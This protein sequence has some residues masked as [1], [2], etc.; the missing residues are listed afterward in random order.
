MLPAL[1]LSALQGVLAVAV[2][3]A[4]GFAGV[5]WSPSLPEWVFG[6]GTICE[7]TMRDHTRELGDGLHERRQRR[8]VPRCAARWEAGGPGP[9]PG[10]AAATRRC[11]EVSGNVRSFLLPDVRK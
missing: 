4:T 5:S 11:S 10:T 8:A 6:Y 9:A 1:G 2:A 3:F 7:V